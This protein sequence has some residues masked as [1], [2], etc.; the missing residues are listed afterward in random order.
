MNE[1][2]GNKKINNIVHLF[3]GGKNMEVILE[4]NMAE[5]SN[6]ETEIYSCEVYELM[7]MNEEIVKRNGFSQMD[8]N[9]IVDK[10]CGRNVRNCSRY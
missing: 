5:C 1:R 6:Q 2:T 8:V 4:K 10:V 7:K 3:K 9:K